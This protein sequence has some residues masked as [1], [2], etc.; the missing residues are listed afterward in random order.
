MVDTHHSYRARMVRSVA[1]SAPDEALTACSIEES[2]LARG[3]MTNGHR[4][5]RRVGYTSS[6]LRNPANV[7]PPWVQEWLTEHQDAPAESLKQASFV[8]DTPGG[9]VARA[10]V[11]M[12][13]E[14]SCIRCH[15][16]RRDMP[17]ELARTLQER[18]PADAGFGYQLGELRGV[19][20]SE[21]P[22]AER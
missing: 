5:Q 11:P 3:P 2:T 12:V 1:P 13:M 14:A 8:A 9:K 18:Y 15:G 21:V 10:V 16:D 22:V 20:W 4:R 7:G 17:P 6:R 19:M